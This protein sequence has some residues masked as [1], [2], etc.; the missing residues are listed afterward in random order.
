MSRRP[1][2]RAGVRIRADHARAN[3][4]IA[5]TALGDPTAGMANA[6]SSAA[7][8]A[9][10]AAADALTGLVL[11]VISAGE[12]REQVELLKEALGSKANEVKD[13]GE[14]L[15]AKSAVQYSPRIARQADAEKLVT[16]A[17]RLVAS[18]DRRLR[19]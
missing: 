19:A 12:H 7:V 4:R 2:D 9:A 18:M 13:L 1:I 11:G 8:T 6:V 10:I 16:C 5:Q 17:A 3:L 15:A 14:L